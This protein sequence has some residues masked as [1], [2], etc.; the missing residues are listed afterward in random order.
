MSDYNPFD[1]LDLPGLG[2]S[3]EQREAA[4]EQMA[5]NVSELYKKLVSKDLPLKLCSDISLSYFVGLQSITVAVAVSMFE[6]G[7]HGDDDPSDIG[8]IS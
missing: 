7:L 3:H 6:R 5:E 1:G 8:N 2:N 4:T